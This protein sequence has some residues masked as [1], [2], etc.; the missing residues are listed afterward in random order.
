MRYLSSLLL[1][2]PLWLAASAWAEEEGSAPAK[3]PAQYITLKPSFVASLGTRSYLKA[4]VSLRAR[5]DVAVKQI[6]HHMP[7]L[8]DGL[9]LLFSAQKFADVEGAEGRE[10]LRQNALVVL[11]ERLTAETGK[12]LVEDLLFTSFVIQR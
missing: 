7:L 1:L 8:R 2:L 12:P 9:V 10:Q 4:D 3:E 6:E 5:G 11:Q